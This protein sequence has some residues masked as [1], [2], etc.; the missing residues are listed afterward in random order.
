MLNDIA[1]FTNAEKQNASIY[2]AKELF[3]ENVPYIVERRITGKVIVFNDHFIRTAREAMS[4]GCMA[5]MNMAETDLFIKFVEYQDNNIFRDITSTTDQAL[6]A[7]NEYMV[8]EVYL[9]NND[10]VNQCYDLQ[11]HTWYVA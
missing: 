1:F 10:V 8:N 3:G 4:T 5:K 7:L 11:S 2:D 6:V 9:F